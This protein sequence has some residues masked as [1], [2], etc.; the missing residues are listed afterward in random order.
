MTPHE[1]VSARTDDPRDQ[2]CDLI[3]VY[4][5]ELGP[6]PRQQP[7]GWSWTIMDFDQ[8]NA[9]VAFGF[10]ANEADAKAA[11]ASWEQANTKP[12][13]SNHDA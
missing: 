6:D 9:E 3:G 11:V 1:W 12:Q 10:S 2:Q 13:G 4:W 5:A 8:D 7:D